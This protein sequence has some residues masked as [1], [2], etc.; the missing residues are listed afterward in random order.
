MQ[1]DNSYSGLYSALNKNTQTTDNSSAAAQGT[2]PN[3]D[4]QTSSF[5]A[6]MA[7]Q[8]GTD[9]IA[10]KAVNATG[11]VTAT[12]GNSA[13]ALE[14]ID[15]ENL[16]TDEDKRLTGWPD[17]QPNWAAIYIALDR[18]D[19]SLQGPITRDYLVGN[20]ELNMVGLAERSQGEGG[21]TSRVVDELL[22][23][24]AG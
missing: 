13:I 15:L 23:R 9:N 14:K 17:A 16:L 2:S 1:I 10:T 18:K 8:M 6:L 11:A 4:S 21:I 24:L 3:L 7:A 19:G 12:S 5:A 20:P 22:E